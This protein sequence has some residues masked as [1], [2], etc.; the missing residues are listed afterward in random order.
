MLGNLSELH[1]QNIKIMCGCCILGIYIYSTMLNPLLVTCVERVE[2]S[3]YR[4]I[5][6]D[7]IN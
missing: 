6:C 1:K 7:I 2:A 4:I 3:L 5:F